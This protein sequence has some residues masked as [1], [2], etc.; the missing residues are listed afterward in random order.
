MPKSLKKRVSQDLA[1]RCSTEKP[2]G[3][4]PAST[5]PVP[6]SLTGRLT[7]RSPRHPHPSVPPTVI[8][9]TYLRENQYR[10][11]NRPLGSRPFHGRVAARPASGPRVLAREIG[12]EHDARLMGDHEFGPRRECD[13]LWRHPTGPEN[14]H[15]AR[16]NGDRVAV[17]GPTKI[18]DPD[19]SRI[20]G[21]EG[22]PWA[23]G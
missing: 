5:H 2:E 20:A 10:F 9:I 18:G 4:P 21:V 16:M 3:R 11:G 23:C 15:L 19:G 1:M 12:Q 14:R 22:A 8:L 6:G 17:V 13:R 7:D